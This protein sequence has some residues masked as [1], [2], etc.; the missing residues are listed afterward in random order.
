[1]K[2]PRPAFSSSAE[3]SLFGASQCGEACIKF[4]AQHP[5]RTTGLILFGA[6]AKGSWTPDHPFAL[7]ANQFDTWRERLI[8]GWGGPI[9]IETF[10]PSLSS[11]PQA[12]AWWAGLLRSAS[13]PGAL[14]A[15]LSAVRDVDVRP[16]SCRR[17]RC[18]RWCCTAV[19]TGQ[20]AWRQAATWRTIYTVPGLSRSRAETI[21][22]RWHAGASNRSDQTLRRRSKARPWV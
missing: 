1:V 15:V 19:L 4:A 7:R 9:G 20:C 5:D 18:P 12:R 11:D 6:V 3:S 21:G 2:T 8:A 14:K 10:G 13:S 17:F 16:L 22:F